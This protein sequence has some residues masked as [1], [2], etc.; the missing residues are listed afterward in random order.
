[1]TTIDR[2]C[3]H[4]LAA[5][6]IAIC[7]ECDQDIC[8]PCHGM[9]L[10]GFAMCT[11]CRAQYAP[12]E[13]FW[14]MAEWRWTFVGFVRTLID[15]ICA[16]R[17]F[18]TRTGPS[19]DWAPAAVFGGICMGVGMFFS[20]LHQYTFRPEFMTTLQGYADKFDITLETARLY[21]FAS[22]PLAAFVSMLMHVFLLFSALKIFGANATLP[23][24]I[25]IV[26]YAAAAYLFLLIP[27]IG[28]FGIGHFLM[29]I[30]LFNLEVNAVRWFY[31]LGFWKS[32]GVVLIPFMFILMLGS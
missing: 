22:I 24:T 11:P 30:W 2:F 5:P 8:A 1:M 10:R 15:V 23:Q 20:T 26:G 7:T 17:S 4:H 13:I 28:T 16:P 3:A 32:M 6:A 31:N 21:V 29:I 25:R 19:A 18:F 14:E 27:P 9:D 12:P